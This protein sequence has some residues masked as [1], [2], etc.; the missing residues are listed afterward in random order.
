MRDQLKTA[1]ELLKAIKDQVPQDLYTFYFKAY[2]LLNILYSALERGVI[3]DRS[4]DI[5]RYLARIVKIRSFEKYG[6]DE[7]IE[8]VGPAIKPVVT[9]TPVVSANLTKPVIDSFNNSVAPGS[10]NSIKRIS[11]F[12]NLNLNTCFRNQYAQSSST[13]FTYTFPSEIKNV[14]SMRLASIEIPN[15]WYLFSSSKKNN[16]FYIDIYDDRGGL[17]QRKTITIPEGNYDTDTLEKFLNTV[18]FGGCGGGDPLLSPIRFFIDPKTLKSRFEIPE[19]KIRYTFIFMDE[20]VANPMNQLGWI[21][22]FRLGKY[23]CSSFLESEGLFDAAGDKYIYMSLADYQ[24]NSNSCNIVGFEKSAIEED[25]LAKIPIV[26]GKLSVIFEENVNPL[27]KI[28]RYN[29]PV[30][31]HKISVKI[32]D[33]FGE[34]LDFH[35]MDFGFTLELEILYEKFHFQDVVG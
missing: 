15:S 5:D 27:A 28:R 21:L 14:V 11:Y 7:L 23:Q 29:G 24:Y 35:Y 32:L 6:V 13:Q 34:I 19:S 30:N 1:K 18:Y 20:S 8:I 16:F 3:Q 31:L 17:I 22:G 12:Q 9:P 4:A 33:K 25:I 2:V 10:L 26:N